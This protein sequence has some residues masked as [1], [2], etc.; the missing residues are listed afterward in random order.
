MSYETTL[1]ALEAGQQAWLADGSPVEPWMLAGPRGLPPST[2]AFLLAPL[3]T[4]GS[5]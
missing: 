4:W 3:A 5:F 2:E 1:G